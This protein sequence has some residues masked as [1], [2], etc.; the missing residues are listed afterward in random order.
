VTNLVASQHK[1]ILGGRVET[2]MTGLMKLAGNVRD[3]ADLVG[4]GWWYEDTIRVRMCKL[5]AE[6]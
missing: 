5:Q 6:G 3:E 2:R 1:S 4:Q